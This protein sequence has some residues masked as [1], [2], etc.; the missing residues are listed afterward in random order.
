MWED[1]RKQEDAKN[2]RQR[3]K[4]VIKQVTVLGG[5]AVTHLFPST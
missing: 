4:W 1:S 2:T 5:G 3:Y